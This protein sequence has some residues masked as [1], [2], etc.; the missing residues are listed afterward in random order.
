[1]NSSSSEYETERIEALY[2]YKIL[3]TEAEPVFDNLV[4]LATNICE[5]P[6]AVINLIDTK[7]HWF[8]SCIGWEGVK[9]KIPFCDFTISYPDLLI[10]T[11][12]LEDERF[13]RNSFTINGK[14]VRFYTG[15]PLKNAAGYS[16]GTLCVLDYT[17]RSLSLKQIES[18]KALGKQVMMILEL[19]RDSIDVQ[20][21]SEKIQ[22]QELSKTAEF[23]EINQRLESEVNQ[24]QEIEKALQISHKYLSGIVDI[25]DDAIISMDKEQN[26]LLFNQGAEKIFGYTAAEVI[27]KPLDILLP[28][29]YHQSH[30]KYVVDF[31]KS[32]DRARRMG[33]RQEIFVRRK[34]GE[35]FPVEASISKLKLDRNIIFTAILRNISEEKK[36]KEA[37]S[38]LSQKHELILN[39][40]GEGLFGLDKSGK[41]TFVNPA[42][43]SLLGYEKQELIG[44]NIDM[45]LANNPCIAKPDADIEC[46]V[47]KFKIQEVSNDIFRR[48]DGSVFPV[49]YIHNPILDRGKVVGAVIAFK[50][51]S[52]RQIIERMK[53][54]FI[55][56]V[57][58]ELRTPLASIHGSLCILD[59]GLIDTSSTKGKRLL[60]IAADS[61]ARLVELVNNILDIERITYG[62]M[63]MHK[64]ICEVSEIIVYAAN[65][66][67]NMA[68]RYGVSLSVS[69]ISAQIWADGDRIIQTLTN[70]LSNAIKFST[71]G[72]NVR[73]S[74]YICEDLETCIGNNKNLSEYFSRRYTGTYVSFQ[75]KDE[76]C[77]IP[78]DKLDNIFD[79]FHQVDT[80]DTR[81]KEGS[82]LGLTICQHIVQQHLG[83]IWV[84]SKLDRGSTFYLILPLHL[85]EE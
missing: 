61:T 10:V 28:T 46:V 29:K 72:G 66:M 55:S 23:I 24:R 64:Q 31:E 35:E 4:Y 8:K 56:V 40:I 48:K 43:I 42:A 34:N 57:S 11:D 38:Q 52:D 75:V 82:G 70:L 6:V 50:D 74:A 44:Q 16:V 27:G 2:E 9:K 19:R 62:K 68:Q 80:S 3:N 85:Y 21:K 17:P 83:K 79:K 13:E 12:C 20:Q 49:E 58:H 63:K 47:R 67:Q 65:K 30:R 1:M 5:T 51:I 22:Q 33:K 76:G 69:T 18:L 25:A 36:S 78:I 73:L 84:E 37:L 59:R 54:E 39:S 71:S 14:L 26:I 7:K 45:L 53:D 81:K 32:N 60:H 15:V 77:G 41:I